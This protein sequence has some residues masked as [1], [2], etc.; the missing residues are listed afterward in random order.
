MC[1]SLNSSLY[2][3]STIFFRVWWSNLAWIAATA[4]T[5]AITTAYFIKRSLLTLTLAGMS[6][7]SMSFEHLNIAYCQIIT[8]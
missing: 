8:C 5:T 6:K 1:V 7:F 2:L 4:Y 3:N